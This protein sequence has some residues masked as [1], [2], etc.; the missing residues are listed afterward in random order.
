[1]IEISLGP[2]VLILDVQGW[3]KLWTL[4]SRLQIPLEN[5]RG[6]RI[7]PEIARGWWKG[8]RAPG[9]HI[10][11]LIVA[12]T[13]YHDGK[14]VFWD[15]RDAERTIVIELLDESYDQLIVEV[16]DPRAAVT[17]IESAVPGPE[18]TGGS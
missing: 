3:S 12:G 2:G 16:A 11:G 15:V 10:P 17:K 8:I 13:F 14:R 4:K 18:P 9:T 1:M 5:I 6:V 7:D